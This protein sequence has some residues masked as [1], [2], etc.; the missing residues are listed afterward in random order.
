MNRKL[1]WPRV[2]NSVEEV[3]LAARRRVLP[4]SRLLMTKQTYN[5]L[6]VE[7]SATD[8]RMVNEMLGHARSAKFVLHRKDRLAPALERLHE[9]GID[10]VLLDPSLPDSKGLA[11]L[12]A[13][14]KRAPGLPIVVLSGLRDEELALEAV[15]VGAQDNLFKEYLDTGVI[16]RALRYAIERA[17]R[18]S[19]EDALQEREAEMRVIGEIHKR[20]LPP[21]SPQLPGFDVA[22]VC[23]PAAGAGGDYF[24]YL[25]MHNGLIG[26]VLADVSSHGIAPAMIM[27]GTRRVLRT[28]TQDSSDIGHILTRANRA[29]AE[30]TEAGQFVT[31]FFAEIDSG[32]RTL[33]YAG[34][35]HE[36]YVLEPSGMVITL[37]STSLPL[38]AVEDSSVPV[39]GPIPL[40]PGQLIV[41]LSDGFEEAQ[42]PDGSLFGVKRVLEM[43]QPLREHSAAEIVAGIV[44]EV[45]DFCQRERANDDITAVVIKVLEG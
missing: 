21:S 37:E 12:R 42:S 4:G 6:L 35:G 26:V 24:D 43:I 1:L 18:E 27:A 8:A 5:V 29:I 40:Q 11:T 22:G 20:L 13:V 3:P 15:Q 39:R 9:G 19:A 34:A 30:D 28:L 17:A 16:E 44:Q 36:A 33:T 25:R 2:W 32:K 10:V 31:M 7:D 41:L 23:V 14:Q 38:G 45:A